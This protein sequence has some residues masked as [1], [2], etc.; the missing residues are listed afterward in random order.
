MNGL[1]KLFNSST[2]WAQLLIPSLWV[3]ANANGVTVDWKVAAT[4]MLAY[5]VKEAA[6]RFGLP[7]PAPTTPPIAP[8]NASGGA[9]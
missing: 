9:L 6:A 1:S 4:G 8:T 3:A 5:G 2:W 7:A